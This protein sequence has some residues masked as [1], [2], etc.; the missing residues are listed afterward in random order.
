LTLN[1]RKPSKNSTGG[2]EFDVY[3]LSYREDII[4]W[5]EKC[6]PYTKSEPAVREAINQYIN[7]I[8]EL[9]GRTIN[10]EESMAITERDNLRR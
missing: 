10:V 4:E 9:T 1:G 8:K 7:L 5:L 3:C 6:L 2:E